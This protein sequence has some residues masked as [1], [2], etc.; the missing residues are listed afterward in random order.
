MKGIT[1]NFDENDIVG[2]LLK[3]GTVKPE[4]QPLLGNGSAN[5]RCWQC[6]YNRHVIVARYAHAT[7]KEQMTA[8]FSV[9]SVPRLYNEDQLPL[10]ES[11]ETAV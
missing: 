11:P 3:A 1:I 10:G 4:K 7:M 9:P 5:A 6:F 8:V 2:C